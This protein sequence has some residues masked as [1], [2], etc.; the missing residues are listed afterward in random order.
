VESARPSHRRRILKLTDVPGWQ[1]RPI[2]Q[3]DR[4]STPTQL[5][6]GSLELRQAETPEGLRKLGCEGHIIRV[7]AV[8]RSKLDDPVADIGSSL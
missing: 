3:L 8:E 7:A 2:I 6:R 1:D 5:A 4:V